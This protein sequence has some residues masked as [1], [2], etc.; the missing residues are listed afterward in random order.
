MQNFSEK[1]RLPLECFLARRVIIDWQR[2]ISSLRDKERKTTENA[3][4]IKDYQF[5]K[6]SAISIRIYI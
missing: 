3:E 6:R 5:H 2:R 4:K 1:K